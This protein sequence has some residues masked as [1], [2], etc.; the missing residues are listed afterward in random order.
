MP[1]PQVVAKGKGSIA[2][3]IISLAKEFGVHVH[4]DPPLARALYSM[5]EVGGVIR[6]VL[7]RAG[8][9]AGVCVSDEEEIQEA[10]E[11]DDGGI[12]AGR[13]RLEVAREFTLL[14]KHLLLL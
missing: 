11:S 9:G 1:A 10:E 7:C 14:D 4:Q 3:R 5:V 2:E 8:G 12:G 6:T 13:K